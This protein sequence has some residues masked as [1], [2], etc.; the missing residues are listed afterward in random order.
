MI[1]IKK[2]ALVIFITTLAG[3]CSGTQEGY[4]F[5]GNLLCPSIWNQ[6]NHQNCINGCAEKTCTEIDTNCA[7]KCGTSCK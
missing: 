4:W 1:L 3:C 2:V 6:T 5:I 7:N